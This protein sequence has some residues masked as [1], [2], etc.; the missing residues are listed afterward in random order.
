ML[1][2]SLKRLLSLFLILCCVMS[3]SV[4][5][6]ADFLEGEPEIRETYSE[7]GE[8][9]DQKMEEERKTQEDEEIKAA[10]RNIIINGIDIGYA[11]GDFFTKNGKTCHNP[12][13]PGERCHNLGCCIASTGVCNCMRYWP[14]GS[15]ATCKVDLK[16]TQCM[17]WAEYCEWAVYGVYDIEY[18]GDFDMIAGGVQGKDC[19]EEFVYSTFIDCSP[20]T[21][22]RVGNDKHSISIISASEEGVVMTDCNADF[23]CGIRV[24]EWTWEEFTEY[25]QARGITYAYSKHS[26]EPYEEPKEI[27]PI[28]LVE[29]TIEPPVKTEEVKEAPAEDDP[30]AENS[31]T[32][33]AEENSDETPLREE[34]NSGKRILTE[35]VKEN[36]Q[37]EVPEKTTEAVKE[38]KEAEAA[39]LKLI[40]LEKRKEP[41]KFDMEEDFMPRVEDMQQKVIEIIENRNCKPIKLLTAKNDLRT[42]TAEKTLEVA[43]M[44]FPEE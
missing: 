29:V 42:A 3:C 40:Y 33:P 24:L 2:N 9:I 44:L 6:A 12:E 38:Q 1:R 17:G 35:P 15:A 14:S 30:E 21:H 7:S 27:K 22:I 26:Y 34:T 31:E 8:V 19:T 37:E 16:S 25:L 13:L 11:D 36:E 23:Y 28:E 10:N 4:V 18:P 43:A 5:Y 20:A 32:E 41:L 39:I